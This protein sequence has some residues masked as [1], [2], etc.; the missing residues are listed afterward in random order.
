M[1]DF[2]RAL[3]SLRQRTADDLSRPGLPREKVL[4]AV[5]QLLEKTLIRVGNLEYA[6]TNGSFGLTTFRDKHAVIE[7]SRLSFRFRGK[8][9]IRRTVPVDDRR[10]VRVVK[11][12]RDLPGCEL[13]Q[14]IDDEGERRT[15]DSSDVNAYLREVTGQ[16]FT[17]KD[18]RT[19]AGTVL[20]AMALS[21][22]G[23]A[24]SE[25]Q[26]KRNVVRAIERV[27]ER[28]GN[29]PAV[30][31]KCYVHPEILNAYL[32]GETVRVI[33]AE[34]ARL[35]GGSIDARSVARPLSWQLL[36]RRLE[37]CEQAA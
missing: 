5:V 37:A 15:V 13:F 11:R 33:G 34:D 32:D 24:E 28:L 14:Y 25:S 21:E 12:C 20:A 10:L 2:G 6:R 1:L 31:R 3:P 4:A 8:S 18:F 22:L 19:W 35:E 26:A 30:C 36:Q 7:G 17:A 23:V 9:G 27:A 16:E 29:T